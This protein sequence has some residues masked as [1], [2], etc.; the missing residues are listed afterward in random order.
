MSGRSPKF[1][2]TTFEDLLNATSSPESAAGLTP[3]VSPAGPTTDPCG[4]VPVPAS[5]SRRRASGKGKPTPATSGPSFDASSPS[6]ILQSSLES[7]LR[8]RLGACGAPEYAL[9]WKHWDMPSGPPICALR[10]SGRRTSDNDCSGWQT[11][12]A[13][14]AA[15]NGSPEDWLKFTEQQQWSGCRL[16]NEVHMA[17]CPTPLVNDEL[18]SGYCYGPKK[19]DGTRPIFLKLPGAAALAAGWPTPTAANAAGACDATSGRKKL[20]PSG[21]CGFLTLTDAAKLAGWATPAARDGKGIPSEGFNV[22]NLPAAVNLASG[23][24]LTSSPAGTAKRGVLNPVFSLWLM[25]YPKE[26]ASCGA[27]AMRSCLKR[28]PSSSKRT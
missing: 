5:R 10:A 1:R 20:P 27:R 12:T 21:K 9:T 7:R 24:P 19:A 14:D 28:R 17:G 16:R 2:Q 26:W 23:P 4:P 6:A 3:S 22:V 11:P 15:R 18:G 8:A 13:E 25:G